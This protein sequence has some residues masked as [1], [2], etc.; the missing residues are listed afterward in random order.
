MTVWD[1]GERAGGNAK[2]AVLRA[3]ERGG[4]A[5]CGWRIFL[6]AGHTGGWRI[7]G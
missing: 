1:G 2:G 7:V 3:L 5:G 4:G 6:P